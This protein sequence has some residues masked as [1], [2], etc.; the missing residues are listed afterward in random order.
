MTAASE[1]ATP[2]EFQTQG[3]GCRAAPKRICDLCYREESAFLAC[4]LACLKQHQRAC[5]PE[6]AA[7]NSEERAHAAARAMNRRFPNSWERYRDHRRR[8]MQLCAELPQGGALCILGA[9]NCSDIDLGELA[10][11]QREI[12]L[13]DLDGEALERARDREPAQVREKIVL[14]PDFDLSGLV[15]QLD[16]WGE[17]FPER[18]ELGKRAVGAAQSVLRALGRRFSA[19]V[20]TCVLSQLALPFRRAWVTSRGNW[21]DLLSALSAIHLATLAGSTESGG[22]SLLVFDTSSSKDT[23]ELALQGALSARELESFVDRARQS[24]TLTLE[25]A[26]EQLLF[27]LGSPG[28]SALVGAAEIGLP[29]LWDLGDATQLVYS[30][31]FSHP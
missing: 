8:V 25:P 20:S 23:P 21:A 19:V 16:E 7:Q 29:W 27:Q 2:P 9:G 13:V 22:K 28:L 3:C 5:H 17:E 26:P 18:T 12:H 10:S 30:L 15:A 4:S 14:H 31:R 1:R 6:H 24:K 11:L